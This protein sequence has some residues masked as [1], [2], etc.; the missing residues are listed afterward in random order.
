MTA[1]P[2]RPREPPAQLSMTPS[3]LG[4]TVALLLSQTV[5]SQS[6]FIEIDGEE[7]VVRE[8][9]QVSHHEGSGWDFTSDDED[10]VREYGSTNIVSSRV[11]PIASSPLFNYPGSGATTNS[12][13]TPG[14]RSS[15]P[16]VRATRGP[17]QPARPSRLNSY[18]P[19][20]RTE[21]SGGGEEVI[22]SIGYHEDSD[23]ISPTRSQHLP[24]Q[25]SSLGP[26][27]PHQTSPRPSNHEPFI[28][29]R[30]DKVPLTSGKSSR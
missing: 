30:L 7:E 15:Q 1:P 29:S 3:Y 18:Y 2:T 11:I 22:S 24:G 12:Y 14:L 19:D 17:A 23:L 27:L 20:L 21:G 10:T 4:L 13:R 6:D 26:V 9:R 8:P 28:G 25:P 16:G 5:S